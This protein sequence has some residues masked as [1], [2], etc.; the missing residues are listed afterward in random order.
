MRETDLQTACSLLL[1]KGHGVWPAQQVQ[2]P[3]FTNGSVQD[4]KALAGVWSLVQREQPVGSIV[5]EYTEGDGPL[6]LQAPGGLFVELAMARLGI[7]EASYG[8]RCHL[9]NSGHYALQRFVDF[10]P[11]QVQTPSFQAPCWTRKQ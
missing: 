2:K 11:P 3:L 9:L 5:A 1:Q 4:V 10:Q 7:D 8:G 6:R